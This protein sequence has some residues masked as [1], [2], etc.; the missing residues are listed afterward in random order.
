MTIR[1][2]QDAFIKFSLQFLPTNIGCY[3]VRNL[4]CFL[5]FI[6]VMEV[7]DSS[8][9]CTISTISALASEIL[10]SFPFKLV[11]FLHP[12]CKAIIAQQLICSRWFATNCTQTFCA[13]GRSIVLPISTILHSCSS[14]SQ[15]PVGCHAQI[16]QLP[17]DAPLPRLGQASFA[18]ALV[19]SPVASRIASQAHPV[20]RHGCLTLQR[21]QE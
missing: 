15:R 7:I 20:E 9:I 5:T 2:E 4:H 10:N 16:V 21:V 18:V 19:G 1:A 11:T 12:T 17:S 3:K 13:S 14:P 6:L 8:K